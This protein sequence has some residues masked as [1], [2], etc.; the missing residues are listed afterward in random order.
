[1][2]CLADCSEISRVT[3]KQPRIALRSIRATRG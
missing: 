1:V 2:G 3:L